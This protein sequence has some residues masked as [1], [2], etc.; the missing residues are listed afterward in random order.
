MRFPAVFVMLL[1]PVL[2]LAQTDLKFET[3]TSKAQGFSILFPGTPKEQTSK[4][5]SAL[6]EL[7]LHNFLLE[8]HQGKAAWIVTSTDYPAGTVKADNQDAIL[9]GVVKGAAQG[10]KGKL[11]SSSKTTLDKNPGR[12]MQADVPN[13]GVYHSRMYLV[14]DRLYQIVVLGPKDL[15]TGAE[16]KKYLD[17][18]KLAK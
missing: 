14:G 1:L 17:S 9:D 13:L 11:I 10:V 7:T 2:A 18:F 16:A 5:P 8:T 4:V 12:V 6:G 3:F 15:A